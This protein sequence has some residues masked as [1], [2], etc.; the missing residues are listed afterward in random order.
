MKIT[1][2]EVI[3]AV[4]GR[5][6]PAAMVQ[7]VGPRWDLPIVVVRMRAEEG[8]EGIGYTLTLNP[9]FHRSLTVLTEALGA[10]I[11]GE[12]LHAP[13]RTVARLL[14]PDQ[15]V[16]PGGILHLAAAALDIAAWDLRGKHLEQPVWRLLGGSTDR[17]RAYDSGNV[18]ALDLDE[19]QAA[20]RQVVDDGHRAIKIWS[21]GGRSGRADELRRR[22]VA[23]REAVGPDV[24]LMIDANQ[25][26]T[27]AHAVRMI[28]AIEDQQLYWV[29]DP[30][31]MYDIDGQ[32]AIVAA[33]DTPICAGEHHY[34]APLLLRTLQA[35]AVD[36][37]M[38]DLLRIGGITRFRKVAAMAEAF[39]AGVCSHLLPEFNAH[40]IAAFP[41]GLITEDFPSAQGLFH[42]LPELV[43]GA[44]VLSERPG[45]GLELD[46]NEL[47][48]Q[49]V[50]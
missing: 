19:L 11:V 21:S 2:V 20:A 46:E 17:P 38:V 39:G 34:A 14:G 12:E 6:T 27:P 22:V 40:C 26:W 47:S 23:V 10:T 30:T 45:F 32:A 4:V 49:R 3:P 24:D 1:G 43:D 9:E 44:F 29:E 41:N 16:G 35:R 31:G 50:N 36:Y 37:L 5:K 13:E 33:V 48:R 42:G 28:R 7:R 18:S 25:R 8:L 15:F